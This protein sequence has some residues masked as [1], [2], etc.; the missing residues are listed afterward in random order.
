L[1]TDKGIILSD[2]LI[3]FLRSQSILMPSIN[4]V[5]RIC[6]EAITRSNRTIYRTLVDSLS[7]EHR[8]KLD[9]ILEKKA[10]NDITVL[11]WLRQSPAAPN[12]KNILEHIGRLNHLSAMGLPSGAERTINQNRLLKISREGCQMTASD[13]AKF[14]Y[15][16]KYATLFAIALETNATIIDEV[17]DLHDRIIGKLF[18]RARRNHEQQFQ[19]SGKEIN[20]KINLYWKIGSALLNARTTGSDPFTAIESVISWDAFYKK[21]YRRSKTC[22]VGRF[23][24]PTSYWRQLFSNQT[25][26]SG[27]A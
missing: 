23:R 6:S 8:T 19:Q 12:A 9:G 27:I 16:R 5:E 2:A 11:T 4:V 25:V 7:D 10:D 24:L 15:F 20:Q 13:L 18:N 14:E 21:Y 1:Q 3:R 17:V 26:C 22:P